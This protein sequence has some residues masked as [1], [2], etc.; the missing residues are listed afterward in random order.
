MTALSAA[1]LATPTPAASAGQ[2]LADLVPHCDMML[3]LIDRCNLPISLH[4]W[5]RN[6]SGAQMVYAN[7]VL[8]TM[9]GATMEQLASASAINLDSLQP[10]LEATSEDDQQPLVFKL[11]TAVVPGHGGG[12]VPTLVTSLVRTA[13]GKIL[14]ARISDVVES[15]AASVGPESGISHN[16]LVDA[17]RTIVASIEQMLKT[18]SDADEGSS[19]YH[20]A[21]L[22]FKD[23]L[24]SEPDLKSM[25][26]AVNRIS[27]H[28]VELANEF[29]KTRQK[30]VESSE[31]IEQIRH[32]LE[33]AKKRGLIDALTTVGNRRFFDIEAARV[34][35]EANA[36]GT[37]FCV[38]MADIDHF[39]S[40]N[41]EH[42]HQTGDMILRMVGRSLSSKVRSTDIVARYGGEEFAVIL[43]ESK[44]QQ[45]RVV[46]EKIR[47]D[48]AQ[49]RFKKRISGEQLGGVTIS[50]GVAEWSLGAQL[51]ETIEAA[52]RALYAAKRAGRN[53]VATSTG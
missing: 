43:P 32:T 7:R 2:A 13:D 5:T 18:A 16:E 48:V 41:D 19:T 6:C 36:T 28:T 1:E 10:A 46:A 38:L 23:V 21:L 42:G 51:E 4:L 50:I 39:K 27:E 35:A 25:T 24:A 49:R 52:D 33:D 11:K 3:H 26:A 37:P 47:T 20:S 31:R 14:L 45:A 12:D 29:Q 30:L 53:R 15:D 40:F 8:R 17:S 9:T 22:E 44:I 34:L